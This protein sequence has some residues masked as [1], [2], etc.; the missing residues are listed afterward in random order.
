M[1]QDGDDRR[2]SRDMTEIDKRNV[3]Q[4]GKGCWANNNIECSVEQLDNEDHDNDAQNHTLN[5]LDFHHNHNNMND[6]NNRNNHGGD[7]YNNNRNDNNNNHNDNNNNHYNSDHD[8][9]HNGDH[10]ETY[11]DDKHHSHNH[12]DSTPPNLDNA[13]NNVP[14]NGSK[15]LPQKA[16]KDDAGVPTVRVSS[17]C[18]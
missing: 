12:E 17:T 14:P 18:F 5:R 1:Q 7:N 4:D 11:S 16:F 13:D 8:P 15:C 2:I 6:D 9:N 3:G 10:D